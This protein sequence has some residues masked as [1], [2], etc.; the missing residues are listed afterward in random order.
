MSFL[1][2]HSRELTV[3][4]LLLIVV[5][6]LMILVPQL[7]KNSLRKRELQ[8][9]E[10]MCALE[11]GLPLTPDDTRTQMANRVAMLVPMVVMITAGTVTC[12]LVA[13]QSDH[14]FTVSVAVWVVGGIV[15]LAAITGGVSLVGRLA[16]LSVGKDPDEV[17][18]VTRID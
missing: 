8:H 12:F 18:S 3:L 1:Q 14:V 2:T 15:S 4:I 10:N 6:T 9:A 5:I 11:N 17:E 13:N 7:L 16:H